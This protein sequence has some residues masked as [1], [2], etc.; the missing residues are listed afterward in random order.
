MFG[1]NNQGP[2]LRVTAS[3]TQI[4]YNSNSVVNKISYLVIEWIDKVCPSD[5][6]YQYKNDN[7]CYK[8]PAHRIMT[9]TNDLFT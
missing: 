4:I 6:I 5:Y 1:L 9:N 3:D 2:Y 8:C 7:K